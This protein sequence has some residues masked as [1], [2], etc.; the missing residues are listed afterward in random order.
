MM[1]LAKGAASFTPTANDIQP[2]RAQEHEIVRV[3]LDVNSQY[4]TYTDVYLDETIWKL[5]S[6]IESKDPLFIYRGIILNPRRTF[7]SY[8]ILDNDR[9]NVLSFDP[10]V[11]VIPKDAIGWTKLNNISEDA[12]VRSVY[13]DYLF[14]DLA[15]LNDLRNIK[16]KKL[17]INRLTN[18]RQ[19]KKNIEKTIIPEPAIEPCVEPLC[20]Y[21][22]KK[23][24]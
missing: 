23:Y 19:K 2:K 3:L 8:K 21:N 6:M 16:Q 7:R 14:T 20:L 18:S 22:E 5:S 11:E 15:R 4:V 17:K 10:K 24:K 1:G 13:Q 9:I 12:R